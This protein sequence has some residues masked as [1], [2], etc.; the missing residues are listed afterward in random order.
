M[1][2]SSNELLC[3]GPICR[4]DNPDAIQ[5]AI[6]MARNRSEMALARALAEKVRA[7][8]SGGVP[9]WFSLGP[10]CLLLLLVLSFTWPMRRAAHA[11]AF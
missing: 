11:F 7:R 6:F 4:L 2:R 1:H 9:S 3:L 5:Y 8:P 10:L